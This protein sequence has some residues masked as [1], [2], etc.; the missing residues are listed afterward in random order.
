[1]QQLDELGR[2][3]G[4][5]NGGCT[6]E[7]LVTATLVPAQ[8][9]SESLAAVAHDARNMVAA[10]GLYCELLEEPGVLSVSY[11]HYAQELRLLAHASCSLVEKL[12]AFD[13]RVTRKQASAVVEA[14][15]PPRQLAADGD[16]PR[17]KKEPGRASDTEERS[18]ARIPGHIHS[19]E[20]LPALPVENLAAELLANRNVLAALA[21]PAIALTVET[22]GGAHSVRLT[23][24]DLTRLLVNLVKNA[25]EAMPAGGRIRLG[26]S[27]WPATGGAAACALITIE[28]NGPGIPPDSLETIF[29][30]GFTSHGQALRKED[31][32]MR[33]RG[34]GLA[35]SRSIVENAG[36]RMWAANRGQGGACFS[37]ELPVEHDHASAGSS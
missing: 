6:R 34:L 13:C 37:I 25:S 32:P 31:W 2:D 14:T 35:I 21:G 28:D 15:I 1:M 3:N 16:T 20:L 27:E 33:H 36:G 8:N 17:P 12:I 11:T 4:M 10:L 19:Q 22:T 29:T 18:A 26:L 7:G 23:G 30:A 9:E 24:E 5:G